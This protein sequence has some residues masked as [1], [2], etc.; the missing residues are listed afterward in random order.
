MLIIPEGY[1]F[2]TAEANFR[3]KNRDDLSIILSSQLAT[4]GAVFTQNKF[5]AAPIKVA[6]EILKKANYKASAVLINSG[7]ANAGTGSLGIENCKKS[8]EIVARELDLSPES[9][10]PASTGVIGEQFRMKAWDIGAKILKKNIGEKNIIDVAKAIMTTD[11]FPKISF[12][13]EK[14]IKILGIAKGAGMICPN[15]ATML[16]F[17]IT[18]VAIEHKLLQ[19]ILE[20]VVELTFNRISV[21]GDTS[22]NDCV[23]VMANGVSGVT[24]SKGDEVQ[25]F[26]ELMH[27]V[28]YDLAYKI[29]QDAEGGTKI[30]HLTVKNAKTLEDAKKAARAIAHSP[31]VKTAIHGE[32]ANWGRIIAALGRSEAHFQLD[33]VGLK[34]GGI[35]IFKHGLPVNMDI[36]A[37]M[38]SHLKK[39]DIFIEVDLGESS[40]HEYFM[41]FSDLTEEYVK[42]N[43]SYRS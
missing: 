16:S 43:G 26:R 35:E 33:K 31:L 36:D 14:N 32:D 29:V 7:I 5:Q 11:T 3:Y 30:I 19:K 17:L 9:I 22:T 27:D 1:L 18:D 40:N 42:I 23:I 13:S 25:K 6:K 8:I 39:Q 37:L 41:L 12:R 34:I 24:I 28:C 15:M 20:E 10:I 2:S 21:D 38:A 4:I